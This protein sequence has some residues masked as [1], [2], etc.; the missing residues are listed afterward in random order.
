[1]YVAIRHAG[2]AWRDV[3]K[4]YAFPVLL[5]A[6]ACG[7]AAGAIRLLPAQ[8]RVDHLVRMIA[9]ALIAGAIYL[10]MIRLLAPQTW[11]TLT[12]R[13]RAMIKR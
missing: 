4:V 2:G 1:M 3:W 12:S 10:P 6:V 9:A 13:V 11:A 5:S 7:A 8:T